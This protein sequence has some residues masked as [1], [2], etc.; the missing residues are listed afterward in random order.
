M[1]PPSLM[2]AHVDSDK[3]EG[4]IKALEEIGVIEIRSN[5]KINVPDL[6][7]VGALMKRKG[8]VTPS[9]RGGSGSSSRS[10]SHAGSQ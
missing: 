2:P 9:S 4:L 5:G 10:P 7:R 3:E 8:G 6:Y 1:S